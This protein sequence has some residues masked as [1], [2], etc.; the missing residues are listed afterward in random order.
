MRSLIIATALIVAFIGTAMAQT[1]QYKLRNADTMYVLATAAN[2]IPKDTY[3]QIHDGLAE[4]C[5][6]V[7]SWDSTGGLIGVYFG[8]GESTLTDPTFAGFVGL[9]VKQNETMKLVKGNSVF[10]KARNSTIT[11][12]DLI[13]ECLSVQ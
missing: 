5:Y 12:G 4:T 8:T 3:M 6:Q 9:S 1:I 7:K 11:S 2:P 13:L 10:I